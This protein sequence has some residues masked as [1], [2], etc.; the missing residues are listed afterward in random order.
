MENSKTWRELNSEETSA[1][2]G[3][4]CLVYPKNLKDHIFSTR[5]SFQKAS[6][7]F[8]NCCLVIAVIAGFILN[9]ALKDPLGEI[10]KKWKI[11]QFLDKENISGH[12]ALNLLDKELE[13]LFLALELNPNICQ[14]ISIV[15]PKLSKHFQ[16]NIAIYRF[17]HQIFESKPI[18]QFPTIFDD[19]LPMISLIFTSNEGENHVDLIRDIVQV[20]KLYR[21]YFCFYCNKIRSETSHRH[22]CFKR[23]NLL[24]RSCKFHK[25]SDTTYISE[26]N[27]SRFCLM[28]SNFKSLT[29]DRCP[30]TFRSKNCQKRHDS[31]CHTQYFCSLCQK[32]STTSSTGDFKTWEQLRDHHDCQKKRCHFCYEFSYRDFHACKILEKKLPT[33]Y[34]NLGF[35]KIYFSNDLKGVPLIAACFVES[36]Q[37]NQKSGQFENKIWINDDFIL[38]PPPQSFG[39]ENFDFTYCPNLKVLKKPPPRFQKLPEIPNFKAENFGQKIIIDIFKMAE[40]FNTCIVTDNDSLNFILASVLELG[41]V[42]KIT[43]QNSS[44]IM[45]ILIPKVCPVIFRNVQCFIKTNPRDYIQSFD[46]KIKHQ[47]FPHSVVTM[48]EFVKIDYTPKLEN[49]VD[50]SDNSELVHQKQKYLENIKEFRP[51]EALINFVVYE[52]KVLSLVCLKFSKEFYSIQQKLCKFFQINPGKN[53]FLMPVFSWNTDTISSLGFELFK[54]YSM[55]DSSDIRSL[56][57]D[58]SIAH[59]NTSL[60]EHELIS[61]LNYKYN[62]D[63]R[64]TYTHKFGQRNFNFLVPDATYE[65]HPDDLPSNFP[66]RSVFYLGCYYHFCQKPGCLA[67]GPGTNTRTS[68]FRDA[69][70]KIRDFERKYPNYAPAF[71]CWE[72][73]WQVLRKKAKIRKF[74]DSK[75]FIARPSFGRLKPRNS[76]KGSLGFPTQ[77]SWT[78]LEN[79]TEKAVLADISSF[80]PYCA[81]FDLPIGSPTILMHQDLKNLTFKS[82]KIVLDGSEIFGIAQVIVYPPK[83]LNLP[84]LLYTTKDNRSVCPLCANC[85]ENFKNIC[86]CKSNSWCDVYTSY[87]LIYAQSLGYNF[88]FLEFWKWPKREPVLKTFIEILALEKVLASG[89]PNLVGKD[90]E[91]W[92]SKINNKYD[93]KITANDFQLNERTRQ[94]VKFILNSFIGKFSQ[95]PIYKNLVYVRSKYEIFDLYEK[96]QILGFPYIGD[97]IT[98]VEHENNERKPDKKSSVIL[99]AWILSIS[100]VIFHKFITLVNQHPKTKLLHFNTDGIFL[101]MPKNF[102]LAQILP[103]GHEIGQFKIDIDDI[104]G[105]WSLSRANYC[106]SKKIGEESLFKATVSGFNLSSHCLENKISSQ[107]YENSFKAFLQSRVSVFKIEQSK[108]K[109][110]KLSHPATYSRVKMKF[111]T[112][113]SKTRVC[114]YESNTI[115]TRPFGY[116]NK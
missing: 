100:R 1:R 99:G 31:I 37:Q 116:I 59:R 11:I 58:Y 102:D 9:G 113:L 55:K 114:I 110:R 56:P 107:V 103:F 49:W 41:I 108:R 73:E 69:E 29:C 94:I 36:G 101:A 70:K 5:T 30:V 48:P 106:Y 65:S 15:G 47:F 21:K 111:A 91:D 33:H 35:L 4:Q 83:G 27:S 22:V 87:E 45:K 74:L 44:D 77:L 86:N 93:L 90:L 8:N 60:G 52:A 105:F 7:F 19:T 57:T 32:W 53:R 82:G 61:W 16:S 104:S 3:T 88:E 13:I 112:K 20:Q 12:K 84:F 85:A 97:K 2:G 40:F 6:D 10:A 39:S 68:N 115:V 95:K 14:N 64:S 51:I 42:P 72:H 18:H 24:C 25:P 43:V 62:L 79:P 28:D 75:N 63:L 34:S 96:G 76:L 109:K 54:I 71:I 38:T 81:T 46:L 67:P 92:I 50:F 78:Q 66:Y 17:D 98:I 26:F 23:Y 89:K 80:Y